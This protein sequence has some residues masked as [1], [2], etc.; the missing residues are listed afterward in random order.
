M[1]EI[2]QFESEIIDNEDGSVTIPSDLLDSLF[3]DALFLNKL[4]E[5]GVESWQGFEMALALYERE[6]E[7]GDNN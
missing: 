7:V 1:G 3:D 4:Y 2:I 6:M 5:Q